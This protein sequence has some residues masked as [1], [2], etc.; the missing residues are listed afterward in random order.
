M[1][2]LVVVREFAFDAGH[3]LPGYPGKCSQHH[4]HRWRLKIGVKGIVNP[5]TGMVIDFKELDRIVSTQIIDQLD[6]QYLNDL[7]N[8]LPDF[9][10]YLPTAELT[11][12]WI[13][14]RFVLLPSLRLAFIKLWETPDSCVEWSSE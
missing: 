13:K 3:H 8:A 9:P 2:Q 7:H 1:E 11:L 5:G 10:S 14:Q 4:G 6:H 12:L